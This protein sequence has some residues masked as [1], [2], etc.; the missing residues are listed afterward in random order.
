[1]WELFLQFKESAHKC[2]FMALIKTTVGKHFLFFFEFPL[3]LYCIM[4]NFNRVGYG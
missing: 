1:M 4:L 3:G 2:E